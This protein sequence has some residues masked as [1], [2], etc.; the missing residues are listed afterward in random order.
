MDQPSSPLCPH[1]IIDDN[2]GNHSLPQSASSDLTSGRYDDAYEPSAAARAYDDEVTLFSEDSVIPYYLDFPHKAKLQCI[3]HDVLLT[4][5]SYLT[6]EEVERKVMVLSWALYNLVWHYASMLWKEFCE[7]TG[8]LE[9]LKEPSVHV[10]FSTKG[11]SIEKIDYRSLYYR[12]PCLP[13]DVN[14]FQ[15]AIDL[16]RDRE[17]QL[18]TV[19]GSEYNLGK[20]QNIQHVVSVLP[21][22]YSEQVKVEGVK[23]IFKAIK[24]SQSA[25]KLPRSVIKGKLNS[26]NE[27]SIQAYAQGDGA[28]AL[29]HFIG[30]EVL[31]KAAGTNIW[32]GNCAAY[33]EGNS[34]FYFFCWY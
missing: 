1:Y 30:F 21:G 2:R 33:C 10:L 29:A 18:K 13:V 27:P 11:A 9:C 34:S 6:V 4:M 15:E 31:H 14:N 12:I 23:I 16:L 26:E 3:P 24:S 19:E 32:E 7:R 8:K 28:E 22:L 5:L 20:V 17:N 25:D